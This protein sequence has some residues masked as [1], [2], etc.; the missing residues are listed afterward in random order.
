[1][2]KF[3]GNPRLKSH[4]AAESTPLFRKMPLLTTYF[5][6]DMKGR[7]VLTLDPELQEE[8]EKA[9]A[10]RYGKYTAL[11]ARRAGSE[12]LKAWAKEKRK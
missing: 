6:E 11:N 5:E 2:S 3:L 1:M 9:V 10:R 8:F 7:L 12:A 4:H